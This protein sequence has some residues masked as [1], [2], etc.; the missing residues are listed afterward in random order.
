MVHILLHHLASLLLNLFSSP[1]YSALRKVCN[2]R[3][4][5]DLIPDGH[6]T[7]NDNNN[8]ASRASSLLVRMCGVTP[9]VPLINPI[10]DAIFAAIQTSPASDIW[11][12]K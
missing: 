3:S 12:L 1:N 8:L 11:L 9:P 7:V 6:G 10:L 4:P 2:S 5:H